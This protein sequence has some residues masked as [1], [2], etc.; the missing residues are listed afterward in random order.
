MFNMWPDVFYLIITNLI[1]FSVFRITPHGTVCV[2]Y[3]FATLSKL[4]P[5]SMQMV[6]Q[7]HRFIIF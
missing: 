1:T 2:I 4:Q 3:N 6:N 5:D 7:N